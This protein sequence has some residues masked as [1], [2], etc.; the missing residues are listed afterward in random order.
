MCGATRDVRYGPK[1][2]MPLFDR[3]ESGFRLRIGFRN[4][5]ENTDVPNLLGCC[6]NVANGSAAVAPPI[7]KM[8]SRR[9]IAS[10]RGSDWASYSLKLLCWNGS[11][12]GYGR[13]VTQ[14]GQS[15]PCNQPGHPYPPPIAVQ[16]PQVKLVLSLPVPAA[17]SNASSETSKVRIS[18]SVFKMMS[19][20][21]LILFASPTPVGASD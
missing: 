2:D 10:P 15:M 20:M 13:A 14:F 8:N 21:A 12:A 5:R 17:I 9:L 4:A 18:S 7:N 11:G 19:T 3:F 1:A 16:T 6:A